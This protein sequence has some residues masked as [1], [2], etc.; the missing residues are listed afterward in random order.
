MTQYRLHLIACVLCLTSLISERLQAD[1]I[2]PTAA[3]LQAL[4]ATQYEIAFVTTQGTTATSSNIATYNNFVTAQADQDSILS[5]LVGATWKAIASTA[6]TPGVNA[7]VNAPSVAGIPVF[8]T[9]GQLVAY[10][11]TASPLYSGAT[12]TDNIDYDQHGNQNLYQAVWTG[13]TANGAADPISPLGGSV[14]PIIGIDSN[15][16]M[17][18]GWIAAG[19]A[20]FLPSTAPLPLYALSSPLTVPEPATLSLVCVAAL[21]VVGASLVRRRKRSA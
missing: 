1:V 7:N 13:S 3:Q 9:D 20:P 4:G 12:L 19:S 18:T 15:G 11:T 17:G 16:T 14:P 21:G 5:G 8:N 10:S 2:L 6:G